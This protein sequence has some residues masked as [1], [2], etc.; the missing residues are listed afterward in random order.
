MNTDIHSDSSKG[1]NEFAKVLTKTLDESL[2]DIDEVTLA[3]LKKSRI[4]VLSYSA[5]ASK[6]WISLSVAASV[7][8]LIALPVLW[9]NS[10]IENSDIADAELMSQEVPPPEQEL[11]DIDMLMAMDDTDV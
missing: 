8:I 3:R 11:D 2:E 5:S 1:D 10:N 9:N 4:Q 6:K 7:A